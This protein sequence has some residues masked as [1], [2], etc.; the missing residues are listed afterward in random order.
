MHRWFLKV[1]SAYISLAY[2]WSSEEASLAEGKLF[3][4]VSIYKA[5]LIS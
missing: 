2:S 4:S 5:T 1:T 3:Y